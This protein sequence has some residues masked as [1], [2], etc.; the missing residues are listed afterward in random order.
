MTATGHAIIG[1]IIAVKISNPYL[2][3]PIAIASHIAA[4]A[5]PHW[6]TGTTAKRKTPKRFFVESLID[7]VLGFVLSFLIIKLLFPQTD[8]L[9]VFV[10]ILASQGLDWLTS[11]YN[12]FGQ[13]KPPFSW[14]YKFQKS[15]DNRM[16]APGGIITQVIALISLIL[17]AKLI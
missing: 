16:Q 4:D 15:F 6:D 3:I 2:A 5:F 13:K 8:L 12:F 7:V 1:T 11:P 10:M 17:L 9:Y 14:F